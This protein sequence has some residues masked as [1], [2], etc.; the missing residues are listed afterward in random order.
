MSSYPLLS[1]SNAVQI[2]KRTD[3]YDLHLAALKINIWKTLT[4]VRICQSDV[5]LVSWKFW[6]SKTKWTP[7]NL[8]TLQFLIH[9]LL[10][11]SGSHCWWFIYFQMCCFRLLMRMNRSDEFQQISS[12][13]ILEDLRPNTTSHY[14]QLSWNAK[15]RWSVWKS[16]PVIVSSWKCRSHSKLTSSSYV[17]LLSLL[18]CCWVSDTAFI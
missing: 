5:I 12:S 7:C 18:T 3:R 2:Q 8:D 11:A 10:L 1:S 16:G 14:Q 6:S 13:Q 17:S 4:A 9:L 15:G